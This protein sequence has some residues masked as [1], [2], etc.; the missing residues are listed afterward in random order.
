M[1]GDMIQTMSKKHKGNN[2]MRLFALL[3]VIGLIAFAG[4]ELNGERQ[5]SAKASLVMETLERIVPGLGIDTGI[6]TGNGRDPL[7]AFSIEGIDVVGV[8]EIP[9]LNIMAPVAA[10]GYKEE[11]FASWL[12]GSPVQG[13]FMVI[14][15][16]NDLFRKIEKLRPGDRVIF[17]DIEGVRYSY[18]VTTQYHLKKWDVGDNDMLLC[19]ESDSDTYFVVGCAVNS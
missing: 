19:Y 18:E 8:L 4:W 16:K 15:D 14:G 13:H 10:K 3:L 7:V 6:S 2:L 12:D 9:A 1:R 11:Y 17:T 5:G